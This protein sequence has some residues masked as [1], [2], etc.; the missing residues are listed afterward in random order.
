MK[1]NGDHVN[2][3]DQ[4][5]DP[6]LFIPFYLTYGRK[7]HLPLEAEKST[8]I[9]NTSQLAGVQQAIDRLSTLRDKKSSFS[10][11]EH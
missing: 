6:V 1:L 10:Q 5:I 3:W 11:E 9:D 2:R 8:A 7:A 4:H